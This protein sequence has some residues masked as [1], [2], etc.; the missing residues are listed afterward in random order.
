MRE[1]LLENFVMMEVQALL[2]YY[3]PSARLYYFRSHNGLQVDGV[4][5]T[6][7]I[8]IPFQVKASQTVVRRMQRRLNVGWN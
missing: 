6:G 4:I 1:P 8:R 7:R 5:D 2:V 3:L